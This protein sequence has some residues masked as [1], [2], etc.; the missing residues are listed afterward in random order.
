MKRILTI[1]IIVSICCLPACASLGSWVKGLITVKAADTIKVS[2]KITGIEQANAKVVD[3]ALIGSGNQANKIDTKTSVG[4]D[5]NNDSEVIKCLIQAN[6]ELQEKLLDKQQQLN[7]KYIWLL[8]YIIGA[9]MLLIFKYELQNRKIT[10]RLLDARDKE[11]E[12]DD[13]L[14]RRA[15]EKEEALHG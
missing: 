1:P 5:I 12:N 3:N 8:R 7:D 4:G 11:D 2:D 15:V 14:I 13:A 6:R 10:N 9:L